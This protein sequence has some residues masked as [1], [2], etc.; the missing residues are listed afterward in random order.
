MSEPKA[1]KEINLNSIK[2]NDGNYY[3]E[4]Q[5]LSTAIQVPKR[6]INTIRKIHELPNGFNHVFVDVLATAINKRRLEDVSESLKVWT[7]NEFKT[8]YYPQCNPNLA[9][10]KLIRT[11]VRELCAG[12]LS[13][14]ETEQLIYFFAKCP[15]G[16]KVSHLIRAHN[17][18]NPVIT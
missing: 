9:F 11:F 13:D 4:N 3:I 1:L 18:L 10:A 15:H 16:Y 17:E 5:K 7:E 8:H 14:S 6:V 2:E 12:Q